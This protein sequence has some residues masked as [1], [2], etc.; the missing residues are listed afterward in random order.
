MLRG[1]S[2][3]HC[4]RKLSAMEVI[5]ICRYPLKGLNAERLERVT[6]SPEAG[7]PHDR[8][9]AIAH[10]S[11]R[12]E[13]GA[14]QWREKTYFLCLMRDEK[15]AQ[16]RADFE[17]ES[18]MMAISRGGKQ[19]VR[20]KATE[21]LGR[22]MI[23]QFFAGFMGA[24]ARGTPKLV[25]AGDQALT[26]TD[27]PFVSIINLASVKDL[28]RV[29][30]APLD[31]LRFRANFYIA[32]GPAWAEFDWVGR[33]IG[34]GRARLE[35]IERIERCAATNVNPESAE[36]DLN[37]PRG[38]QKGFGHVDMGVYA[39]VVAGGEVARADSVSLAS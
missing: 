20:A 27:Q 1:L 24:A 34:L 36:R 9:F 29:I 30:R 10:G 5:E 3:V 17:P 15:L 2:F 4:N 18:G 31:P 7:L 13:L 19:V 39:R 28:E 8:R 37:I 25:E 26:D 12:F 11:T 23:G 14:P 32:G 16:L 38:L 35:V 6:L 21:A 22:A 33:E